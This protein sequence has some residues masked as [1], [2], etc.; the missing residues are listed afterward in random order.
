MGDYRDK[1]GSERVDAPEKIDLTN[2]MLDVY[3]GVKRLWWLL[4]GLIIICAVQSYF[5]VSTSYQS[6]YVASATVSVTSVGGMDYVNAQ[7]AQQMAEVFPYI[8]TSGVLKDVVAEDM[9]LDSMPGSID[10]KADDGTN[11]LTI[12]VS[13]ND[14]QMAY[15]TLKSVIKNY[16][17]VAEFVLGETKL[18]ILDETGIPTDTK[19]VEVIRGSYKRG[20]LKGAI[21][22]CVILLLYVLSRRTVKSRKDLK[23]NINLQDLGS[24][25]YVRTKKRKKET[26][27]NSVSLLNERISMSYLE[28]IRKLRIRIMKDV[29]KKEYQTLLVTS[30]IPGEGKTT[31]SANLAISIAQQGKKVL[32]VDCD[33][34]NPSIAG[35][36][37]EQEPHPGLGSVLKKEVPLSEAITNVKLPKERTN[38]NGSLHVIFGGAP[39]GENSLLIGSGRMRALIKALKS[40]YDIIILDTAPSELLADAPLLGKYVDAALYVIRYDYTKLREIRE[41]VESLALSGID[42]LGYVFNGD[43]SSG[44]VGLTINTINKTYDLDIQNY[45]TISFDDLVNVIDEIGGVTVFISEEEAAYYRENG[46]PDIQAGDVT[47]TGAQ[48]LAHARNRTLGNDFERTRRQRSVMYGIYR[49]IMEKKDP[50]ALLP[51]INYAVNHVKTNMSVSEMYSM[52]KDVLSVDDLKMQQTCIPQDGT[53]TDITYEDMQVLKV[54]FDANKKKIEQLLY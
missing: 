35:V 50:S 38:E 41:G 16:P 25:P 52:A 39:D 3:H 33:L 5:S 53:Y 26:F 27:Y 54:D 1:S 22:G 47:L 51:L 8:L 48:A 9:G 28:A 12:S 46:M 31:L 37:N 24:I 49:K 17:K 6:K 4:I 15:K 29:E 19:R 13:G 34:R 43:N 20:A 32:L 45:I 11:L 2:I 21:I 7:S 10:V 40:K 36:M 30:S 44:G 42:M 23:K 14:P 18:T